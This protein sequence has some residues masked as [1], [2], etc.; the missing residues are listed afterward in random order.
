RAG[1]EADKW[2]LFVRDRQSDKTRDLTEKIDRSVG[3]FMWDNNVIYFS[4]ENRGE[5]L[6]AATSP[7]VENFALPEPYGDKSLRQLHADDLIIS[8]HTL[9]FSQMLATSPSEIWRF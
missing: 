9:F 6:F 2:R 4:F 5:S 7:E 3:S 1:F 8:G